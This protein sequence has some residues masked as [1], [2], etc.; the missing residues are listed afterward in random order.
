[1]I[2]HYPD[3]VRVARHGGLPREDAEEVAQDALVLLF[4][5]SARREVE[6]LSHDS[7]QNR[8][9]Q[10]RSLRG[11]LRDVV[12]LLT[13]NRI[14]HR[15][16]HVDPLVSIDALGESRDQR[17]SPREFEL[18]D[19]GAHVFASL[20]EAEA[21]LLRLDLLGYRSHEIGVEL[22]IPASTVRVRKK[23]L[24]ERLRRDPT[25]R[26]HADELM[27]GEWTVRRER[28][29][30]GGGNGRDHSD[31]DPDDRGD[32]GGNGDASGSGSADGGVPVGS[33]NE[34]AAATDPVCPRLETLLAEYGE[35]CR[36]R[37][38]DPWPALRSDQGG[39]EDES[40]KPRP[41]L[42]GSILSEL[43]RHRRWV[44]PLGALALAV[45]LLAWIAPW[46]DALF[47]PSQKRWPQ[48]PLAGSAGSGTVAPSSSV[49]TAHPLEHLRNRADVS[50]LPDLPPTIE[51]FS[52]QR[53]TR[54]RFAAAHATAG[55]G[56]LMADAFALYR[57]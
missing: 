23:R 32:P 52:E 43:M 15:I 35:I 24:L 53:G 12:G 11:W 26:R 21:T 42:G 19:F 6:V 7:I 3:L 39:R 44:A 18:L 36:K 8:L 28:E 30:P 31:R 50:V 56:L 33:G 10:I 14:R 40:G 47:Q 13:R 22:G 48:T 1:M 9:G 57:L 29:T 54:A 4:Q 46:E 49:T 27:E 17:R 38:I 41:N 2:D 45:V 25:I 37:G 16:R 51:I 5:K 34:V 55:G 20:D